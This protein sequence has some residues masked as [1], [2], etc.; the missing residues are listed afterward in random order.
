MGWSCR[1]SSVIQELIN[2]L[3]LLTYRTTTPGGNLLMAYLLLCRISCLINTGSPHWIPRWTCAVDYQRINDWSKVVIKHVNY[4]HTHGFVAYVTRGGCLLIAPQ[5]CLIYNQ[6]KFR[7]HSRVCLLM[8]GS[9]N[10]QLVFM[11]TNFIPWLITL[12]RVYTGEEL[13]ITCHLPGNGD[14][15]Y[16][17]RVGDWFQ[18]L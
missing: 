2:F 11:Q 12:T 5:S 13:M 10:Y 3:Y 15:F 7:A 16:G 17:E 14:W 1:C 9:P 6:H 18:V 8:R 4:L